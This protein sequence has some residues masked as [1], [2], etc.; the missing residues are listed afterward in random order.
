MLC[1]DGLSQDNRRRFPCGFN[2]RRRD[3]LISPQK[4]PHQ[5]FHVAQGRSL[6]FPVKPDWAI[7]SI[8]IRK[9]ESRSG[10]MHTN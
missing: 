7:M 10:C 9:A 6:P 2:I 8:G 3:S 1:S 4:I 5:K